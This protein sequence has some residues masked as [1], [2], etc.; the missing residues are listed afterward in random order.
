M[1]LSN[2][3]K[4]SLDEL[5]AKSSKLI[6]NSRNVIGSVANA[7]YTNFEIGKYIIEEEQKGEDR[8]QYGARILDSLSAYLS[9]KYGRGF[10]RTNLAAMRKFYMV[11]R[12]RDSRIVRSAIAQLPDLQTNGIVQSVI[13]QSFIDAA[14][15]PFP[16]SW[17]HY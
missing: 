6:E 15:W 17:T 8:A 7:V 10:S 13:A 9:D 4:N 14:N 2:I 11:Y 3:E 12:D 16:L 5:Y 1:I